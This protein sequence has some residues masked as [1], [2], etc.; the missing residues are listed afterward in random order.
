MTADSPSLTH[1]LVADA[2]GHIDSDRIAAIIATGATLEELVEAH[3]WACDDG[4]ALAE[5]RHTLSGRVAAL[6]DILTAD[7]AMWRPDR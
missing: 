6:Y 1:D 5:M 4:D 7:D 3:A 2:V